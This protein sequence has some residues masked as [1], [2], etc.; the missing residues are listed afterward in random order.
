MQQKN[1][2]DIEVDIINC[3][4]KTHA[5]ALGHVQ[6]RQY[7]VKIKKENSNMEFHTHI[8]LFSNRS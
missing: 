3:K 1:I 8:I 4:V 6:S 5:Y 2:V 7:I